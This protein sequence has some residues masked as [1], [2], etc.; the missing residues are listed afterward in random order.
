MRVMNPA[1]FKLIHFGARS[2]WRRLGRFSRTP[3]GV[4]LILFGVVVLGLA[5]GPSLAAGFFMRGQNVMP[6]FAD[7]LEP[8]LPFGLMLMTLVFAFTAAGERA[9]M[10]TPAEVDFLFP[11]PF[12]RREL[13]SYKIG[14]S[15]IGMALWSLLM[16]GFTLVYLRSW[17]AGFVGIM[18]MALFFQLTGLVSS[19]IGQIVVESARTRLRQF[20]LAAIGLLLIL[21]LGQA[22]TRVGLVPSLQLVNEIN[23]SWGV[24]IVL[25]PF[26]PF[27]RAIMAGQIF[28]TLVVWGLAAAGIDLALLG[29][30]F[31]LDANYLESA[32]A[33]TQKVL[34]FKQRVAK[35][36][37]VAPPALKG[38][39]RLR[40]PRPGWLWGV[41]PIAWRQTLIALRTAHPV[42]IAS[43]LTL[44]IFMIAIRYAASVQ[45]GSLTPPVAAIGIGVLAYLAFIFSLNISWGFRGD[46]D[47]MDCLKSLPIRSTAIAAGEIG[48]AALVLVLVQL[49]LL[50][51]V[52]AASGQSPTPVLVAAGFAPIYDVLMLGAGNLLF[53]I[54]PTRMGGTTSADFQ[55]VTRNLIFMML[56]V[57]LLIPVFGIPALVGV[58]ASF[59]DDWSW[60]AYLAAAWLTMALETLVM[61]ALLSWAY[62]RFDPSA[63]TPA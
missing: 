48:G 47:H 61:L 34:E 52:A 62:D 45:P 12:E 51:F 58:L 43:T 19:L 33:T 31:R 7:R 39:A 20:A 40:V 22:A 44:A 57:L 13:L 23:H 56:Q 46:L 5:V 54:Y 15:L 18:L 36:G 60:R 2:T 27:A 3:R 55:H 21:G 35:G 26:E 63:H 42:A 6:P 32:A 17:F 41:G 59:L 1:L 25:A 10:F 24:R 53:L 38:S 14:R 16:S 50:A 4:F 11:G 37:G 49:P 28:P 29:L 30:V 8:F 9:F